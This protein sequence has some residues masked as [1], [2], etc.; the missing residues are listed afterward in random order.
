[1]ASAIPYTRFVPSL[2]TISNSPCR[3]IA[4][5][6][7]GHLL[8]I[9][10]HAD[11]LPVD[12]TTNRAFPMMA[13]EYPDGILYFDL[14]PFYSPVGC[15]FSWARVFYVIK[16]RFIMFILCHNLRDCACNRHVDIAYSSIALMTILQRVRRASVMVIMIPVRVLCLISDSSLVVVRFYIASSI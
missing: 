15:V 1:M 14:W 3:N 12:C 8:T 5:A 10:E 7:T 13:K 11:K 9:K 16:L 2:L 4:S 6:V